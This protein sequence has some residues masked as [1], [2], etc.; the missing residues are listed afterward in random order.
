MSLSKV[1]VEFIKGKPQGPP[2]TKDANNKKGRV[3]CYLICPKRK[4]IFIIEI[5]SIAYFVKQVFQCTHLLKH[6][7]SHSSDTQN[8]CLHT[9]FKFLSFKVNL[10]KY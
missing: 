8:K 10:R 9:H 1:K 7:Y 3:L 5:Y 2:R 6:T 4:E